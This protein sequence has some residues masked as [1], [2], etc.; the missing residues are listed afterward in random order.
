[1]A[2]RTE[3]I[4]VNVDV[5]GDKSLTLLAQRFAKLGSVAATAA[6]TIGSA[7]ATVAGVASLAGP[8]VTGMLALA[9]ATA[10]VGKAAVSLAPLAATLPAL[11]GGWALFIGTL[12]LAGPA[13]GKALSPIGEAFK[14]LQGRVGQIAS[15]GLPALARGFVKVNF[16]AIR[17]SMEAIA[18]ATNHVT[19]NALKWVNSLSGQ[20]A[21]RQVTEAT[22]DA[23][24]RLALPMDRVVKAFGEMVKRV[25]GG[26]IGGL[27]TQLERAAEATARW[28]DSI[29]S[30]DID[31]ALKSLSGWGQ[32]LRDTFVA[33][34]DVGR[35]MAD[36]E[37]AVKK[38]SDTVAGLAIVLGA[39]TGNWLA[40]LAGAFSIAV[41]H[42]DGLKSAFADGASFFTE[43]WQGISQ[44]PTLRGIGESIATA[45]RGAADSFR[46]FTKEIGPQFQETIRAIKSAWDEWGP[47]I[48]AWWDGV[49]R[50][51]FSALGAFLGV[52]LMQFLRLTEGI[53]LFASTAGAVIRDMSQRVL[54]ALGVIVNAAAKAFGWIPGIGP[55]LQQAAAD[56]NAFRDRVN[57]A[58]KGIRDETVVVNVVTKSHGGA[59]Q[60]LG[61]G[62]TASAF[63]S[64][65]PFGPGVALV[66][67]EGPE[68]VRFK[69]HGEVISADRTRKLVGSQAGGG[70]MGGGTMTATA[71]I[72]LQ[73]NAREVWA[74]IVEFAVTRNKTPASLWSARAR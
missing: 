10:A 51:V 31:G 7:G 16:P 30:G 23:A 49:G 2:T 12:K 19:V 69:G 71:P 61:R 9:K 56:F 22:A 29:D 5:D 65:G 72:V 66:G 28:M 35:W 43:L 13:M 52:S 57:A 62:F 37:G 4:E 11:A 59:V 47:V 20:Q 15:H 48:K 36:N 39:A 40:V 74:G 38:F 34:R 17:Q 58:L 14:N 27:A 6:K 21:I 53:A 33:L 42:W 60:Q 18:A 26:V 25:G 41:N 44:D 1:M 54:A 45:M 63:A 46:K 32:K 67:E 70:G 8:A 73:M 68:L 55:K 64:G 50:P 3:R 24:T